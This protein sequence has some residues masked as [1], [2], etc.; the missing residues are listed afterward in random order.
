MTDW[1]GG[2]M[3]VSQHSGRKG[4]GKHNDR[5]FLSGLSPEE[6]RELAPHIDPDKSGQ[7]YIWHRYSKQDPNMLLQDVDRKFYEERYSAAQERI[8]ERNRAQ[9]HPERCKTIEDLVR[10]K[11]TQPEEMIIQIGDRD[12]HAD[13]AKF[14]KAVV[15]YCNEMLKWSREHG[16]HMQLLSVAIHCDETTPHA[17]IRRCWDYQDPDGLP[18]LGQNKALEA[19]GVELPDPEKPVGRYNNRKIKFDAEMRGKWQEIAKKYGYEIDTE[20]IKGKKHLEKSEYIAQQKKD[21]AKEIAGLQSKVGAL[22][23]ELDETKQKLEKAEKYHGEVRESIEV[24]KEQKLEAL[25]D[26]DEARTERDTEK[27]LASAEKALL[28]AKIPE[29]EEFAVEP[30]KTTITGKIK[31]P[32]AVLVHRGQYEELKSYAKTLTAGKKLYQ[33]IERE[34]KVMQR[35]ADEKNKNWLDRTED[36]TALLIEA[37]QDRQREM[38]RQMQR[39]IDR[40]EREAAEKEKARSKMQEQ[41]SELQ[42][43]VRDL[44]TRLRKLESAGDQL[45]E[46][47][48]DHPDFFLHTEDGGI[49]YQPEFDRNPP[50]YEYDDQE[51]VSSDGWEQPSRSYYSRDDDWDR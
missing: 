47:E 5:S 20:P 4:N 50:E 18:R 25:R 42:E 3:K 6:K 10:G 36:N 16:G 11:Q 29:V 14:K 27:A 12:D 51:Y 44:Q 17:H 21:L 7:N 41:N 30:A 45:R 40:L 22:Q 46:V 19:S 1:E 48:R 35:A 49:L 26:R 15:E 8:N 34:R 28:T 43:Q 9:G 39:E 13:N 38:Q 37:E 24:A 23:E 33:G 32:E 2:G 31:R